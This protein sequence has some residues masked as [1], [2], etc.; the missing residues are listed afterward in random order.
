MI[1][2]TWQGVA[3]TESFSQH[4]DAEMVTSFNLKRSLLSEHDKNC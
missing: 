4:S 1:Q 3:L 2:V